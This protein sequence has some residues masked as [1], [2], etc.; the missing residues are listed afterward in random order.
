MLAALIFSC[1]TFVFSVLAQQ[2]LVDVPSVMFDAG[3]WR[4][5]VNY[6][7]ANSTKMYNLYKLTSSCTTRLQ[8]QEIFCL[9]KSIEVSVTDDNDPTSIQLLTIESTVPYNCSVNVQ[10]PDQTALIP[11][12]SRGELSLPGGNY[13]IRMNMKDGNTTDILGYRGYAIRASIPVENIVL[14]SKCQSD[15]HQNGP[16]ILKD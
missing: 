6:L 2:Q 13:T 4:V 15:L 5:N 16:I 1:F 10:N 3:L 7:E 9:G 14:A 12:Y 8:F 11:A